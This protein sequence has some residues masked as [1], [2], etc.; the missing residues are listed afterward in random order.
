MTDWQSL[1]LAALSVGILIA[2]THLTTLFWARMLGVSMKKR[3]S[4]T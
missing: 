1:L 4:L 3:R 2:S